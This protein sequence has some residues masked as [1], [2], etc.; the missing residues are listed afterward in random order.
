MGF[1]VSKTEAEHIQCN[2]SST[3]DRGVVSLYETVVHPC[4][5]FGYLGTVIQKE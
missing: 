2:F 3:D 1:K 4:D 5:H